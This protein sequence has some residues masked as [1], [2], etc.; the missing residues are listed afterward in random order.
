MPELDPIY[1]SVKEAARI[2]GVSTW[3]MY[4]RLDQ[5]VIKSRYEGR[6]RLVDMESLRTYAAGLPEVAPV[7]TE[8]DAS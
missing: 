2:L 8:A 3:L 6:K 7:K 5:Q 1:V 4:Q